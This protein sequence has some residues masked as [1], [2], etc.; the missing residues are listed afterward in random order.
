[1]FVELR[2]VKKS[3][4]SGN[5]NIVVL[6]SIDFSVEQGTTLALT[7]ESGSGKSTLLHL[8]ACLDKP[9]E[10]SI[11][12]EGQDITILNDKDLARLRRTKVGIIFQNFNLVSSLNVKANLAFQAKLAGNYDDHLLEYLAKKLNLHWTI[13]I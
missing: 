6:R 4:K 5:Q 10:G 11:I 3:Y 8:I 9:D 13:P 1:M 7:G 12:L 2:N